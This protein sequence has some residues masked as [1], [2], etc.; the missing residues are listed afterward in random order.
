M[1]AS[2]LGL[3]VCWARCLYCKGQQQG[4]VVVV[5][6]GYSNSGYI[7]VYEYENWRHGLQGSQLAAC[8]T[9][10]GQVICSSNGRSDQDGSKVLARIKALTG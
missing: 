3:G 8:F 5:A 2:S 10:L 4:T 1:P 6:T 7:Q 9:F